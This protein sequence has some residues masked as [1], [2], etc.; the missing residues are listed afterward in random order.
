ML[1]SL[2]ILLS[3]SSFQWNPM[4]FKA[5]TRSGVS[6]DFL[7]PPL[8]RALYCLRWHFTQVASLR[9]GKKLLGTLQW[10]SDMQKTL[11]SVHLS[12]HREAWDENTKPRSE[13]AFQRALQTSDWSLFFPCLNWYRWRF[14]WTVWFVWVLVRYNTKIVIKNHFNSLT[15]LASG[16]FG[17]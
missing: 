17:L 11:S 5:A 16:G 6:V 7:L 13:R 14:T 15:H 10:P 4:E 2:G 8:F 12:C 3:P 9:L 1:L